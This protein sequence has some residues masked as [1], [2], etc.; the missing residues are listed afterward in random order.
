MRRY[1]RPPRPS[2]WLSSR[3]RVLSGR[4]IGESERETCRRSGHFETT[5]ELPGEQVNELHTQR[6]GFGNVEIVWY[7]RS[8]VGDLRCVD[9]P[10][11]GLAAER[12]LEAEGVR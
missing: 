3:R 12:G 5:A 8:I 1:V 2:L 4:P 7:W 11:D 9:A 10:A 6:S